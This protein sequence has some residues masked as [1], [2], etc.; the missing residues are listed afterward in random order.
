MSTLLATDTLLWMK[1]KVLVHV[2]E[3]NVKAIFFT[4]NANSQ[5]CVMVLWTAVM[6]CQN[7]TYVGH[8]FLTEVIHI[9][10]IC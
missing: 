7:L 9:V 10:F 5:F 3:L 2:Y 4:F 8:V 1:T 6:T